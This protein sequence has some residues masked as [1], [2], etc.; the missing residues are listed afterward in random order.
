MESEKVLTPT[1]LTEL[2][3]RYNDALVDVDLA[4]M[5]REQGREDAATW[6]A[7]AERGMAAA[8]SDVDA[9]EINAF[10]VSTMTSDRYAIIKRLRGRERP[11]PWSKIG[12]IL[13]MSKQ[14]AQQWYDTYNLRPRIE[15]PTRKAG[16][17]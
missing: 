7:N 14:A 17:S 12:E 16:P 8:I 2:Y 11:V 1:E 6:V 9:L 4:Q 5:V 10:L 13:G 3:V 15:N